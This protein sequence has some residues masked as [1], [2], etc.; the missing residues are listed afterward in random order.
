MLPVPT[1]SACAPATLRVSTMAPLMA[2][3]EI[4]AGLTALGIRDHR[5]EHVFGYGTVEYASGDW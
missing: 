3:L 5:A 2:T 1:T 4:E